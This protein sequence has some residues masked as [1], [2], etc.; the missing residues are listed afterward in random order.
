MRVSSI[1]KKVVYCVIWFAVCYVGWHLF[2]HWVDLKREANAEA[3]R[4]AAAEAAANT[5]PV[6]TLDEFDRIEKGMTLDEVQAII[7]APGK[8]KDGRILEGMPG[9]PAGGGH[10]VFEW[11]NAD[12]GWMQVAMQDGRVRLK[13]ENRLK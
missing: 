10:R 9:F 2:T 12:G 1:V 13:Y 7:G 11:S 3:A 5:P 8:E 6:V 4:R